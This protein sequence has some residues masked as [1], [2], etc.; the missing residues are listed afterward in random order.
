VFELKS[1]ETGV[2]SPVM[3]PLWSDKFQLRNKPCTELLV[4]VVR[5]LP[6]M[7]VDDVPGAP[8]V[9]DEAISL[10][11]ANLTGAMLVMRWLS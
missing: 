1:S 10:E 2:M 5:A 7:H 8:P 9:P 3:L 11:A 4:F 6:N